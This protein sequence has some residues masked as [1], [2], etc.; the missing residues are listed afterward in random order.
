M[1]IGSIML[2]FRETG[3]Q[4]AKHG[5]VRAHDKLHGSLLKSAPVVHVIEGSLQ[6]EAWG[7]AAA[8]VTRGEVETRNQGRDTDCTNNSLLTDFG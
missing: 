3:G 7:A 6:C 8:E 4:R 2:L 1:Y 5:P